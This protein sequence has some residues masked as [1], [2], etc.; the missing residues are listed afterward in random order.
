ML[1]VVLRIH[2]Y[3]H[4][5]LQGSPGKMWLP[6]LAASRKPGRKR[7]I[8]MRRE[9]VRCYERLAAD[10]IVSLSFFR[11]REVSAGVVV[12]LLGGAARVCI[13]FLDLERRAVCRRRGAL[14]RRSV[15]NLPPALS[16]K[17]REGPGSL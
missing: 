4:F 8:A 13:C 16:Y 12:G 7:Q 5:L 15:H 17:A 9:A 3:A 6:V 2:P 14:R 1:R 11:S 10:P